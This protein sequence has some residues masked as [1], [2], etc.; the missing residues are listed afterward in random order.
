MGLDRIMDERISYGGFACR[1]ADVYRHARA[2]TGSWKAADR[3]AFTG[4]AVYP[5]QLPELTGN[6]VAAFDALDAG[7]GLDAAMLAAAPG[8]PALVG[9]E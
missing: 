4:E 3:F 5:G 9:K 8:A 7:D 2:V 1:R 6:L